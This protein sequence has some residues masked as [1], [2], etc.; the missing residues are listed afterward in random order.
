MTTEK[1]DK[2]ETLEV[3]KVV[4]LFKSNGLIGLNIPHFES[5]S[6]QQK[7]VA[8]IVDAYNENKVALIEAGTGT[9]KSMAY[10]VPAMYWAVQA[11]E[12]TLISTNTINLQ[13]QLLHKDIPAL[14]KALNLE[15]KAV[16]VKGMGNY[17]CLRKVHESLEEM[18]LFPTD[19]QQ[20]LQKIEKWAQSTND[21]SKTSLSFVPTH[22][23]WE[24]VCAEGDT[25]NRDKC[26]FYKNCHFFRAR[27]RAKDAHI[28]ISNHSLLF[29]DL[30]V[31]GVSEKGNGILP[32][33]SRVILDEAHNIEEI[34]TDHFAWKASGLFILKTLAR[35]ITTKQN[36]TFGKLPLLYRQILRMY[37]HEGPKDVQAILNKINSEIPALRRELTQITNESFGCYA[38]FIN[39]IHPPEEATDQSGLE[40][41]ENKLRILQQHHQHPSWKEEVIEQSQDLIK[42]LKKFI[43]TLHSLEAD[44]SSLNNEKLNEQTEGVRSEISALSNRLEDTCNT[45]KQFIIPEIPPS[46]VRWVETKKYRQQEHVELIDADLDISKLLVNNLFRK[47]PT[48]ILCSATLTTNNHFKFIRNRLGLVPGLMDGKPVTENQYQSPFNYQKQAILAVPTDLPP[49]SDPNFT[50]EA[51]KA[52]FAA[53]QASQGNAF[54]LFTS[55]SMMRYCHSLLEK[56]LENLRLPILMQGQD[57]RKNLLHKFKTINKSIL[58]GTDSF[59]EGVD[60]SGE[61]LRCVIIV[62]LP[63]Q[64]PKEPIV[65]ARMEAILANGGSPFF[66][67]SIPNAIVKFMQGFGRLIRNRKD[68]GCILCLD[69]RL[70]KKPYGKLFI[71]SLPNCQK[72]FVDTPSMYKLMVDFY[73]KTYYLT[74]Q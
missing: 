17:V 22:Q 62:K 31:R 46:K 71:N 18:T 54:V 11:K 49:P 52:I 13:E 67:F 20:E 27:N 24:K 58:F 56:K 51:S 69:S 29:S 12:K 1:L 37:G 32:D 36:K 34:A 45:L 63:F 5:R 40:I 35:L 3:K 57:T 38:E 25:C 59:W 64:V 43:Q 74:K 16:L 61:A 4:D 66:D 44:I 55:Y 21:G 73:K 30:A 8:N 10:L 28:L 48:T 6:D 9:G 23:T 42:L 53:V 7:M 15:I 50:K 47:F 70:I 2:L 72:F 19:E 14:A 26:P 65:Q 33:Y 68:R 41:K 60:V 39:I